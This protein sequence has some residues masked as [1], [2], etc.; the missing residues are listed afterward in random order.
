MS[1][2]SPRAVR[3]GDVPAL[4]ALNNAHA[5]EL[6][7]Q[8][9][10]QFDALL[11]QACWTRTAGNAQALLIA[12]NQDAAYDNPNFA[13]LRARFKRFVYI[14]RVV[15]APAL[16]GQ[17]VAGALYRELLTQARDWQQPRLVCEINL[18]PPNPASVTFHQRLG[19][20]QVGQADLPGGK[21]VGYFACPL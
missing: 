10:A 3:D 11:Q 15:V 16:Q 4:L 19:F 12:L 8:E 9:P 18:D 5:A 7:W 17:G 20:E 6:S 2:A 14:D 21:R 13:W 1:Q